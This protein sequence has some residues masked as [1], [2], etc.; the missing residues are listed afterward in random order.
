MATSHQNCDKNIGDR[1]ATRNNKNKGERFFV[2]FLLISSAECSP[3]D[4][5]I[6]LQNND[7]LAS[8]LGGIF[9]ERFNFLRSSAAAGARIFV[10]VFHSNSTLVPLFS[11]IIA[12]TAITYFIVIILRTYFKKLGSSSL[13]RCRKS[14]EVPAMLAGPLEAVLIFVGVWDGTSKEEEIR[15]KKK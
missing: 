3:T 15:N 11:F 13:V 8:I 2:L 6:F 12:G 7:L 9:T 5:S 1:R 10:S 14:P 4:R